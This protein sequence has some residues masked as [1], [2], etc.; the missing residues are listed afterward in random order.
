MSVNI[1]DN[2]LEISDDERAM[3]SMGYKQELHRGLNEFANFA[4]GL[5]DASVLVSL[6]SV[7]TY[8]LMTG[9]PV[10]IV[11]GWLIIFFFTMC[12]AYSLAEICSA[13]PSAGSV[14]HWAGMIVPQKWNPISSYICGWANFLGNA[15][16]DASFAY[17]F[18]LFVSCSITASGSSE[19]L[20]TGALVGIA[21][22]VLTIWTLF[23]FINVSQIGWVNSFSAIFQI[24][25]LVVI[26]IGLFTLTPKLSTSSFVFTQYYNGTGW[27]SPGYVV[28]I[29]LLTG[30]FGFTGYEGSAHL[31]EETHGSRIIAPRGI[32]NTCYSGGIIGF[33]L[34]LALLYNTYNITD[35]LSGPTDVATVNVF[36]YAGGSGFGSFLSWL[37]AVNLFLAGISSPTITSRIA[38]ALLRDGAFPYSSYWSKVDDNTKSPI[39]ALLLVFIFDAV[40]LL[41]PLVSEIAFTSILGICTIGLDISYAIPIVLKLV[42]AYD[43]F[44]NTPMSLGK[45]SNIINILAASFLIFTSILMFLPPTY[46]V[47]TESMNWTVLVVAGFALV[48]FTLW[49]LYAQ[50][51]FKGPKR[52]KAD[53]NVSTDESIRLLQD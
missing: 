44:P 1:K 20:S 27:S 28:A 11:W 3:Q 12:V 2:E 9:G 35:I 21:Q 38:Y 4:F 50:D 14:Y 52:G 22:A 17:S 39:S 51:N 30:L 42:F 37:I 46:P 47:T 33:G 40:L 45:F 24:L 43:T 53:I 6:C 32:I 15:A 36:L 26:V 41:L 48:S 16:G 25:S 10:T 29:S 31:A 23:N 7:F 5:T 19:I 13:Y 34:I 49:I 8:G 18:A